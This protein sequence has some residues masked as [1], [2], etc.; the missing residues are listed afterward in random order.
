MGASPLI[1]TIEKI[2][3]FLPTK[4]QMRSYND[5]DESKAKQKSSIAPKQEKKGGLVKENLHNTNKHQ[6]L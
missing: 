4:S 3:P 5:T 2:F 1:A 6:I